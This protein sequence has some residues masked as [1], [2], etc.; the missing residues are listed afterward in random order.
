MLFLLHV[1]TQPEY[2]RIPDILCPQSF[3]VYELIADAI[4]EG[5]VEMRST[6]V[7]M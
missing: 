7:S 3:P 2:C 6:T 4:V 1:S 5:A